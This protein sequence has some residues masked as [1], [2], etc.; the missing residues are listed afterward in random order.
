MT[1]PAAATAT[2][3]AVHAVSF[4]LL[5]FLASRPDV[6]FQQAEAQFSLL[7]ITDS[8]TH[9]SAALDPVVAERMWH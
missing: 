9:I 8:T 1:D 4:K 5:T 2:A 7:H 3:S 6:W